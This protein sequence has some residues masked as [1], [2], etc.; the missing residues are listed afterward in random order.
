VKARVLLSHVADDLSGVVRR[1][2]VYDEYI[3]LRGNGKDYVDDFF[4]I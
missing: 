3:Q 4:D 2:I 1:I